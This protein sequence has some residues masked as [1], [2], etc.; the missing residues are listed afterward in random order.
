MCITKEFLYDIVS[1]CMDS[2]DEQQLYN[3]SSLDITIDCDEQLCRKNQFSC[4][5]GTSVP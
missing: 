1:D 5:D 3:T 2:T 4:G